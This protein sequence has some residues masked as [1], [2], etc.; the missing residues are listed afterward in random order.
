MATFADFLAMRWG[1]LATTQELKQ[2]ARIISRNVWQM[3]GLSAAVPFFEKPGDNQLSLFDDFELQAAPS[4]KLLSP[5]IKNWRAKKILEFR[6][7]IKS[8]GKDMKF[9]YV[10]GNPPYQETTDSES[11]RMPPIYNLFMDAAYQIADKVELITPARFLFNAGYTPKSWNEKM[12]HDPHFKVLFYEPKSDQIFQNT[13]IKGG[14]VITYRD[15]NENFGEIGVF[16]KYPELNDIVKKVARRTDSYMN[17]IAYPPLSYGLTE[18]VAIDYPDSL[19]RLR[20]SAFTKLA[21]IFHSEKPK[22]KHQYI[23]IYGLLN[24]K[25]VKRFVRKDYIKDKSGIL[26]KWSLLLPEASGIGSF[27]EK[28]PAGE[29]ASPGTAFL[30]TFVGLGAFD[31]KQDVLSLEKYIRTKFARALLGI[32]K[33][34]QHCSPNVWRLVPLQD[35]TSSSDIDWSLSIPEIDAQLYKKYKLTKEEIAFIESN[36]KEMT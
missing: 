21:E 36:V 1:R 10:I 13:E 6:Q 16:T 32:Y 19:D 27:G 26:N 17:S 24:G 28:T 30:Q 20:T 5:K 35:F 7:L 4:E 3:D 9:D 2:A 18:Q 8:R 14:I 23:S 34:T 22:D 33:I 11:T 29:I 25:R 12:L 15:A 31:S